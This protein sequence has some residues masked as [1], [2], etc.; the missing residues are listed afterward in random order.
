METD[1]AGAGLP[2]VPGG[3]VTSTRPSRLR[4]AP[5][6]PRRCDGSSSA[7]SSTGEHRRRASAPAGSAARARRR[8]PRDAGG[9]AVP[10][11]RRSLIASSPK[12]SR[13]QL[14][15]RR[16]LRAA[17]SPAPPAPAPVSDCRT[18]LSVR[19]VA[20]CDAAKLRHALEFAPQGGTRVRIDAAVRRAGGGGALLVSRAMAGETIS[21]ARGAPSADI[22][23]QEAV[24]DAA[25]RALAEDWEKALSYGTGIGHPGPL[26]VGRRAPRRARRRAR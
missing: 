6:A 24:R 7:S 9:A 16:P 3:A 11:R 18:C 23:P 13:D 21:F 26:P 10:A 25:A 8:R 1:P 20:I 17:A 22:L 4:R 14:P 5:R 2:A 15:P 19:A 12:P